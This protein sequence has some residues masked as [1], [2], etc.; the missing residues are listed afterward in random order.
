[1][2]SSVDQWKTFRSLVGS[3]LFAALALTLGTT[4]AVAQEGQPVP[5]T[6]V[7]KAAPAAG[8]AAPAAAPAGAPA[9]GAEGGP[10]ESAWVKV[11]RKNNQTDNKQICLVQ[12]EG[13]DPNTGIVL[14]T[15]AVRSVEGEIK[16]SLLV[17]VTTAYSLIIPAGVQIKIDDGEPIPLQYTICLPTSCQ[18]QMELTKELF[19]KMRKGRQLIVA[20]LNAQQKSMGFP[21]PLTGFG[22]AFDG[23]PID[24]AKYEEARRQMMEQ[25]RQRQIELARKANEQPPAG[26]PPQ[27]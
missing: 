21:L 6:T 16:Q 18:A 4:L 9:A 24:N 23:P 7:P 27:P 19:D 8:A 2:N 15:A 3:A 26:A 22:K 20:A 10:E 1:M 11:C 14:A 13:L 17:G 5:K 12:H 25:S